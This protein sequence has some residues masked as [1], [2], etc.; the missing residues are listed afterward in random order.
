M[1]VSMKL[2]MDISINRKMKFYRKKV[3]NYCGKLI[4]LQPKRPHKLR[5]GFG[6][7]FASLCKKKKSLRTQ[8]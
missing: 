5:S 3:L 6:D 7:F 2:A 1:L 4:F 8:V